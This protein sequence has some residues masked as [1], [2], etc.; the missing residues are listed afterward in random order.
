MFS[1]L[2]E[3]QACGDRFLTSFS[4]ERK[5]K[6]TFTDNTTFYASCV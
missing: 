4:S 5:S 2:I 1:E 6:C 3:K